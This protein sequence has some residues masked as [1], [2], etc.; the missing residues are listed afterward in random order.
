MSCPCL[1][2]PGSACEYRACGNSSFSFPCLCRENRCDVRGSERICNNPSLCSSR[3]ISAGAVKGCVKTLA[4]ARMHE[5]CRTA[6]IHTPL[7]AQHFCRQHKHEFR[8]ARTRDS[9]NSG[10]QWASSELAFRSLGPFLA[11]S[12]SLHVGSEIEIEFRAAGGS[13][14]GSDRVP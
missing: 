1:G 5:D 4:M 12:Q 9:Y 14:M 8:T 10:A 2:L 7:C 3:R 13:T 11:V 6:W